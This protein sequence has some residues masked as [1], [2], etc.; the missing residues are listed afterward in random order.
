MLVCFQQ[1]LFTCAWIP[2][3]GMICGPSNPHCSP[4]WPA[5]SFWTVTSYPWLACPPGKHILLF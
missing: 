5:G 4:T 3:F 1:A 2:R